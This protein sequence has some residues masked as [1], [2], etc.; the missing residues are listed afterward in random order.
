[1][2]VYTDQKTRHICTFIHHT[3]IVIRSVST[4][5]SSVCVPCEFPADKRTGGSLVPLIQSLAAEV[6]MLPAPHHLHQYVR[7]GGQDEV[8]R[9]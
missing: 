8:E 3:L 5:Y 2:Y 4:V 9:K 6:V 1:M 7:H